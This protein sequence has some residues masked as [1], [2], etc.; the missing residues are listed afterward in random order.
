[1]IEGFD[2][3][4]LLNSLDVDARIEEQALKKDMIP[5]CMYDV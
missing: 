4:A 2:G 1:M 3:P 5:R